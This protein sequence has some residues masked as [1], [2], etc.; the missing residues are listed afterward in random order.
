TYAIYLFSGGVTFEGC[1][2][3]APKDTVL[4]TGS[5]LDKDGNPVKELTIE[6]TKYELW[7]AGTQVD[8]LNAADVLGNGRFAYDAETNVLTVSGSCIN[9]GSYVIINGIDGLTLYIADSALLSGGTEA[10]STSKDLTITGPGMLMVESNSGCG[11]LVEKGAALT[12]EGA[13]IIVEGRWGI[14]GTPSG[15]TLTV[16]SSRI[17][18]K[19]TDGALCDFDGG[20]TLEDCAVTAP[21]PYHLADGSVCDELGKATEVYIAPDLTH[22]ETR[23]L[24][25][26][27]SRE[28]VITV[29][30]NTGDVHT[31][32]EA[33]AAEPVLV[34][35]YDADGRFLGVAW[36]SAPGDIPAV[37]PAADALTL[38]W[39]DG[40]LNPKAEAETVPM[41]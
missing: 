41:E 17:H 22:K 3:T 27:D 30:T 32:G 36:V 14:G 31:A 12:I 13:S 25:D 34:A 40:D 20:I 19:G 5:S 6:P 24:T 35:A 21:D 16:R 28:V 37:H 9:K 8:A 15:E 38:F 2:I 26:K 10:V 4:T 18:A 1:G 39:V 29:T 33:S 23:T 11:I 7:I